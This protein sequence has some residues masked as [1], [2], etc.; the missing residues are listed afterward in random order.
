MRRVDLDELEA[1]AQRPLRR[2]G[3]RLHNPLDAGRLERLRHR[4]IFRKGQR[5]RRHD[6]PAAL[7]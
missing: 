7:R 1:R 6:R 5:A 3:E 2:R 4:M